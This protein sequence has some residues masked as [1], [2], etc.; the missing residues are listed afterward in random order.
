M[1]KTNQSDNITKELLPGQVLGLYI[2]NALKGGWRMW[3]V[4]WA[5]DMYGRDADIVATCLSDF[6]ITSE[7]ISGTEEF[8]R[9]AKE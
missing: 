7:M 2:A 3:A 8:K 5:W 4:R 6:G 1:I 9:L